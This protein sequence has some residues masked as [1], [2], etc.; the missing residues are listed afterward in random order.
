MLRAALIFD[1]V[2]LHLSRLKDR[3]GDSYFL[4]PQ[5]VDANL[6]VAYNCTCQHG[7]LEEK[8]HERGKYSLQVGLN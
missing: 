1:H 5:I 7:Y 8:V 4:A 3:C 6:A 2:P